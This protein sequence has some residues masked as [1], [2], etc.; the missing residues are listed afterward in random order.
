MN[1][2][3]K[4]A[5]YPKAVLFDLL[6]A[7]LDSWTLWNVASGGEEHGRRWRTEYLRLTYGCGAYVP[8]EQLVR[9]AARNTG[10]PESAAQEL[11]AQWSTL[12]VWSGAREAL[13]MLQPHCKLAVVTNCSCRLGHEA[14]FRL[15]IA[16]DAVVTAEEAG[17]YKPH[18]QPYQLTLQR[19]GISAREAAFVAGSGYDMFGTSRVGLRTYWHNRVGLKLPTGAP[20]PEVQSAT[21]DSLGGWLQGFQL[22]LMESS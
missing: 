13:L 6:T 8:Y 16:W 12:P 7:L 4:P 1:L 2:S 22:S 18:P 11:E 17:F 19:L 5:A 21:L 15:G 10:L 20:T 9:Q 3:S 14:A